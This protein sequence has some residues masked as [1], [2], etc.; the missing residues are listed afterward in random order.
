MSTSHSLPNTP[1]AKEKIFKKTFPKRDSNRR[2]LA[3]NGRT[4]EERT[5]FWQFLMVFRDL[6]QNQISNRHQIF[7]DFE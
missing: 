2:T 5:D 6:L 7:T 1:E 4:D 3:P